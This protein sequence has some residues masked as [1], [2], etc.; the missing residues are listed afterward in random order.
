MI[1]NDLRIASRWVDTTSDI[2]LEVFSQPAKKC[3]LAK[4]GLVNKE[5]DSCE[6]V[7]MFFG[8]WVF[9]PGEFLA[10]L[11]LFLGGCSQCDPL[12]TDQEKV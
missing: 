12:D 1:P 6:F 4:A 3:R 5:P 10:R 7:K 9:L 8:I 2:N 11:E